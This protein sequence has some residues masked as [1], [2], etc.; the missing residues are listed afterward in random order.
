LTQ[1]HDPKANG[2]AAAAILSAAVGCFSLGVIAVAA[3]GSKR[4][5][6][7]LAFYRPTGPLSGVTSLALAAW[8]V[9][10]LIL[11]RLWR[12]KSVKFGRISLF[13]A[14]FLALGLLLTFPPFSD[15]L[16]GH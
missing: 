14:I 3:D 12:D 6:L 7:A 4:L 13:A 9:C 10:W 2:P 11:G 16:L 8:L 5:A 1:P 15:L